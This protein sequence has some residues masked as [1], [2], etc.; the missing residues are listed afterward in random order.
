MPHRSRQ[1]SN[2]RRP[3]QRSNTRR[4]KQRSSTRRPK[5][6]ST[7]RLSRRYRAASPLDPL[8]WVASELW[9]GHTPCTIYHC[10]HNGYYPNTETHVSRLYPGRL[11]F[12]NDEKPTWWS[13]H[14]FVYIMCNNSTEPEF[15]VISKD[16]GTYA[17]LPNTAWEIIQ[18]GKLTTAANERIFT[19]LS[20]VSIF[21]LMNPPTD[22]VVSLR[23]LLSEGENKTELCFSSNNGD[24]VYYDTQIRYT[25]GS[26]AT[27]IACRDEDDD[28]YIVLLPLDNTNY[29]VLEVHCLHQEDAKNVEKWLETNVFENYKVDD[30]DMVL[31]KRNRSIEDFLTQ[32][33]QSMRI[34]SEHPLIEPE[35]DENDL[36]QCRFCDV[37]AGSFFHPI[38]VSVA[39]SAAGETTPSLPMRTAAWKKYATRTIRRLKWE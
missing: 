25:Y 4:S 35:P 6:R 5:Q 23:H 2:T 22:A 12:R 19:A 33:A 9:L 31:Q 7:Q 13:V 28:E 18:V 34:S 38:V 27:K 24:V 32:M 15:G 8:A 10:V 29:L 21:T 39:S 36:W 3:K 30:D 14:N 37:D 1:R 26:F 20:G 11:K 16:D 17:K